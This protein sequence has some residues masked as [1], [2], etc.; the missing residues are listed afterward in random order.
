MITST[1]PSPLTPY[2]HTYVA[3]VQLGLHAGHP[4]TRAGGF[5]DSFAYLWILYPPTGL[6]CLTSLE[7]DVP[8]AAV[9]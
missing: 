6:P 7:E 5:P 3:D 8:S 2:I 9:T 1:R 4:I